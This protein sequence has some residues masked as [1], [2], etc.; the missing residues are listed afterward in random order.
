MR[1]SAVKL[2]QEQKIV[3]GI[4]QVERFS[5]QTKRFF[6]RFRVFLFWQNRDQIPL[7]ALK[8]RKIMIILP[9]KGLIKI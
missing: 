3:L 9:S 6:R 7:R 5:T 2:A 8:M 1:Y 4:T